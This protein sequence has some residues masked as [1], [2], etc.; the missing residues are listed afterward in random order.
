[1]SGSHGSLPTQNASLVSTFGAGG[2]GAAR[3]GRSGITAGG[4][5][6][7]GGCKPICVN[8]SVCSFGPRKWAQHMS[9]LGFYGLK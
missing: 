4:G 2:D 3:A 6:G 5:G 7:G 1:M 9:I 8:H